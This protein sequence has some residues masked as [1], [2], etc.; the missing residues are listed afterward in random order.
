M[1]T[2]QTF[3]PAFGLAD[4]S[5]FVMKAIVLLKQ[6]GLPFQEAPADVTKAPKGKLPVLL[7]DGQT[8]PDS[9]L[10]R[11]HLEDKHGLDFDR[12]LD[13]EQRGIAWALEKMME[14]HLYWAVVHERWMVD[15]NFFAGPVHFFKAVPALIRPIVIRI[16]RGKVK[17]NLFGHGLGRHS[18]EE[19]R[20]LAF[21]DIDALSDVLGARKFL[22]GDSESGVDAAFFAFM[23]SGLCP[24]FETKLRHHLATKSNIV[25]YVDRMK[26]KYFPGY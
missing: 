9:S 21:K 10:I 25:A 16:V 26:A 4:P 2:L 14:D 12:G 20:K 24:L 23:W 17:R 11:F 19:R 18:Q 15:R 8:I 22:M 6:S 13:V 3:G 5:P 1:L 7:D